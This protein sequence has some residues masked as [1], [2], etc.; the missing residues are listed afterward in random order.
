MFYELVTKDVRLN[1]ILMHLPLFVICLFVFFLTLVV[2]NDFCCFEKGVVITES[3]I[4][5]PAALTI[6]IVFSTVVSFSCFNA[7]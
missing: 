4:V 5:R 7:T 3:N 2:Q 6:L 1:E